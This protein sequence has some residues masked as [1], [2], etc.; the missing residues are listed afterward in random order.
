MEQLIFCLFFIVIFIFIFIQQKS[1][2]PKKKTTSFPKWF[3]NH[4]DI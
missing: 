2:Q 4:V 3:Q 1:Y